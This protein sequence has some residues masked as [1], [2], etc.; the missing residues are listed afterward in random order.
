MIVLFLFGSYCQYHHDVLGAQRG[1][2]MIPLYDIFVF[3]SLGGFSPPE[4]S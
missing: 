1:N 2:L 4:T 3:L